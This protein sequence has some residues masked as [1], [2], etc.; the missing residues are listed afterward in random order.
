MASRARVAFTASSTEEATADAQAE[1]VPFESPALA[2]SGIT[3]TWG[4]GGGPVLDRV[5]LDLA[6]GARAWVGGR[7][8]AG[9]T[10][11]LRIIAG[12]IRPDAGAVTLCGLDPERDR[13]R[14]QRRIGFLS[15]GNASLYARLSGRQH[16]NYWSG[17]AMMRRSGR[18][19]AIEQALSRFRL[20]DFAD[21]RVDR[22]SLG[23]R[24]RV[25]LA[26]TFLHEPEVVLLDEPSTSL[27]DAGVTLLADELERVR[28]RSGMAI[29]CSPSTER[30]KLAFDFRY[31]IRDARLEPADG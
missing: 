22:L 12:L 24:Q 16:L 29:W 30:E 1:V 20:E 13:E 18:Q 3:K 2:V 26:M 27:D 7:N 28:A 4:K 23:Q 9:K 10:T 31:E 5:N 8:G 21:R 11:L 14:F 25:R 17:L 6:P 19:L 15:G